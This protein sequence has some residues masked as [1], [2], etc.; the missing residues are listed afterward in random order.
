M[1]A[2]RWASR[3]RARR[4]GSTLSSAAANALG[5]CAST[6]LGAFL[7]DRAPALAGLAAGG[8]FCCLGASEARGWFLDEPS[9][10]A[11][12]A[13]RGDAAA[14]A[15]PMTLNNIA[16]GIGA[17]LAGYSVAAMGVGAFAAS[18]IMWGLGAAAGRA[19]AAATRLDPRVLAASIF[20]SLG[21]AQ[22]ADAAGLRGS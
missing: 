4:R 22:L 6:G 15:V 2:C 10:L 21:L 20:L 1:L 14:L 13:A 16:G 5:A 19:G 9:P 12:L 17:G 3:A 18:F 8:I 11:S 7:G